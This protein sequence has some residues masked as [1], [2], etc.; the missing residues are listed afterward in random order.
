MAFFFFFWEGANLDTLVL[1]T[2][3][4]AGGF[5]KG[6]KT[7]VFFFQILAGSGGGNYVLFFFGVGKSW[8]RWFCAL[9]FRQEGSG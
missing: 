4:Q 2:F 7:M 9:F 1:R 8:K 3:L 5:R 6:K